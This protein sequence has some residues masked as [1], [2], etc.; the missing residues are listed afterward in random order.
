MRVY[1]SSITNGDTRQSFGLA[2]HAVDSKRLGKF[3]AQRIADS[4]ITVGEVRCTDF[5]IEEHPRG[6]SA[7]SFELPSELILFA[8]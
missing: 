8:R 6:Y 4:G 1:V 7:L 5:R 2:S 3:Q